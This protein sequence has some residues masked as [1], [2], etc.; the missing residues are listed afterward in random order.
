M[1]ALAMIPATVLLSVLALAPAA[2]ADRSLQA[3]EQCR[4]MAADEYQLDRQNARFWQMSQAGRY[5]RVWLKLRTDDDA[6]R[7]R[8]LCKVHKLRPENASIKT[9]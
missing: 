8:A 1:K 5:I 9:L 6:D 2:A 4:D 7:V 3:I